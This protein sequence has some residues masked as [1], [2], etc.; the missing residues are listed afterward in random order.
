LLQRLARFSDIEVYVYTSTDAVNSEMGR[1]VWDTLGREARVRTPGNTLLAWMEAVTSD[2]LDVLVLLDPIM[3]VHT[4]IVGCFRLAPVQVATWGHPDTTGLPCVDAYVSSSIFEEPEAMSNYTEDLVRMKTMGICYTPIDAFL[5]ACRRGGESSLLSLLR[6]E[7]R[8][9]QRVAFG[10]PRDKHVY[11]IPGLSLKLHPMMDRVVKE[12]L[13]LDPCGV[14][15]MLSGR[16]NDLFDRVFDRMSR[17]LGPDVLQR[18]IIL[19]PIADVMDFLRFV[20][21]MDVVLDTMPF[22]GCITTF[23]CFSA[24]GKCVIT[25][26]CGKLYGRF[27]QGLYKA[28]GSTTCIDA[29]VAKDTDD[30]VRKAVALGVDDALRMRCECDIVDRLPRIMNDSSSALEWHEKLVSWCMQDR[31]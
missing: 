14:V 25:R 16:N 17:T 19:P 20:H 30:Y 7:G 10:I 3:D 4:Y 12:V 5:P 24:G 9:A 13:E 28:M 1:V 31:I 29:L 15:V 27:T 11:G 18:L 26:P 21:C 2:A 6:G 23:E 8:D 22:G